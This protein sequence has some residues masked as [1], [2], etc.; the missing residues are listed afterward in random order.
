MNGDD[1]YMAFLKA[2]DEM[3]STEYVLASLERIAV[4]LNEE[5]WYSKANHVF[6]A[7]NKIKSLSNE[8]QELKNE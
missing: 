4:F 5:G 2:E 3:N 1:L 8:V 7:I 6:R